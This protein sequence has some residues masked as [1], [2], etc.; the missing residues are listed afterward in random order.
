MPYLS[1]AKYLLPFFAGVV[2]M[3]LYHSAVISGIEA[4]KATTV[5][6]QATV[7]VK[8][9]KQDTQDND[10]NVSQY[11]EQ[12]TAANQSAETLRKRLDDGSISLR[13]CRAD[14]IAARVSASN[15]DA[16]KDKAIADFAAYRADVIDLVRQGKELDAWVVA[17][18][19]FINR[20]EKSPR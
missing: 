2:A 19:E 12:I 13:M 10:A 14:T 8:Q 20:N 18:H 7:V 1:L 5:A 16:A 6:T 4:E 3:W 11:L 15:S 9:V 17:A